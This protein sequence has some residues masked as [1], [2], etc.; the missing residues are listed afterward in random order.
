M[1]EIAIEC[2]KEVNRNLEKYR[3]KPVSSIFNNHKRETL[4]V[5]CDWHFGLDVNSYWNIYNPDVCKERLQKVLEQAIA[6]S[7]ENK[8]KVINILNLGDLIS[9]RIHAQIRIQSRM[10][11]VAQTVQVGALLEDFILQLRK[12]DFVVKYHSCLDNHSRVEPNRKESLQLESF[13][14]FIHWHLQTAFRN[15]PDV[16]I[17]D[18]EYGEDIIC[19]E[20]LG[21]KIVGVHGDKDDPKTVVKN[22]TSLLS[23]KPDLICTAHKHHFAADETNKCPVLCCPS[24]MGQDQYALDYRLDSSPA[25]LLVIVTEDNA[26]YAVHRLLG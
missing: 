4:L 10:D 18:N 25:Q 5:L 11:A 22:L 9:G 24:L 1:K 7:N 8:S 19:T 6:I 15:I 21:H 23:F 13:A 20:I 16:F 2:A 26:M 14:K 17:Y 12:N 3:F